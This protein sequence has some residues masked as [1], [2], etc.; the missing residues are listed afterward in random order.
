MV[1]KGLVFIA[2]ALVV[3]FG[4]VA[5]AHF[6]SST[7]KRTPTLTTED[8]VRSKPTSSG[9]GSSSRYT[10]GAIAWQYRLANA[11][12]MA[13]ESDGL[14]IVDIY[15]DWC[16]WCKKMDSDIYASPRVAA[17]SKRDVFLKF[18]A[19]DNGEGEAFAKRMRVSGYPTTM[20]LN[21]DGEF[22]KSASG[23]M[24]TPENFVQFVENARQRS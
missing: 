2:A 16:G 18:D 15:T 21:R 19:E 13:R 22:L 12:Q 6:Q 11:K 14:I 23:Y 9:G 17:L 1:V 3:A 24:R 8:V 10:G 20:V 5:L 4:V 7:M